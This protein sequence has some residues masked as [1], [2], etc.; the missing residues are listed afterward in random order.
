MLWFILLVSLGA[1]VHS[2][3]T[4]T[5]SLHKRQMQNSTIPQY[6]LDHAPLLWLDANEEFFPSDIASQLTSTY[7]TIDQDP[8]P[9]PPAPLTLSNL[10]TLN[11]YG[12][13]GL[14]VYLHS[15][16]GI[17]SYPTTAWF[18]GVR[19]MSGSIGS[20]TA[21]TIIV[22]PKLSNV[23]DVFY[24]SFFAFNRGNFLFGNPELELGDHV[25]DWEH[26]TIRFDTSTSP[27]TPTQ[28]WFSQHSYGQ[29]FS[30]AALEK[31]SSGMRP[32]VYVAR[33]THAN[34]ATPFTHDHTLPNGWN[35]LLGPLID[36]T[37][38]GTL[39]DPILNSFYYSYELITGTFQP[40][41][42]EP[43]A[44]LYYSGRWGDPRLPNGASGQR[45]FFTFKK[46]DAGPTGPRDKNLGR[47]NVCPDGM[48]CTIRPV[49]TPKT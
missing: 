47:S 10:D 23:T 49:L 40:Y 20:A 46:Y 13:G 25:G 37:S 6:A 24:F 34:Y 28:M 2:L 33:G 3:P 15:R 22:V 29:A 11:G 38:R 8:I 41:N 16:E 27:P 7:P 1:L 30:W 42:N 31:D 36:F 21:S 43:T 4:F 17:N 14:N 48:N 12:S 9:S 26:S 5:S 18:R 39:W 44:W 32:Y 19:P 35:S 45:D